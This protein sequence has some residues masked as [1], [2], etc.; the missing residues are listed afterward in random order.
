[1]VVVVAVLPIPLLVALAAQESFTFFT[2][3]E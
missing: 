3:Y 2:N 1:L